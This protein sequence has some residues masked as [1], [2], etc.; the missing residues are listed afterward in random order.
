MVSSTKLSKILSQNN[1]QY[2]MDYFKFNNSKSRKV[3]FFVYIGKGIDAAGT[4]W[5]TNFDAG[6][7]IQITEEEFKAAQRS[8]NENEPEMGDEVVVLEYTPSALRY[9][10]VELITDHSRTDINGNEIRYRLARLI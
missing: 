2:T 5:D 10:T 3:P 4:K 1:S 8:Y 9:S 6:N 7:K